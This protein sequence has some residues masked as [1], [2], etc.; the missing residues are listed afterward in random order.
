MTTT[1]AFDLQGHRGARGLLPENTLPAFERAMQIGVNTLELDVGVTKDGV[2]VISHDRALNPEITRDATGAYLTAPVLVNKLTLAEIK[3]YDV[4]R[5]NPDS[6]YA[7]RFAQQQPID[8]T[9]MPALSTLFKRVK[10]IEAHQQQALRAAGPPQGSMAPSGGGSTGRAAPSVGAGVQ[11]NIETKISPEKSHE[12]V[13]PSV[14][15]RKLMDVIRKHGMASRVT[16]QS[17]DWRTLQLIAEMQ[18]GQAKQVKLSCLT[19]QQPWTNNITPASGKG[20]FWTGSVRAADHPDVPSMVKAA[21]C[22][23]WSPYFADITPALVSKA[24]TLGLKV[25]PWTTNTEAD[26]ATVIDAGA[27]GLITDYPDRA[28]A[29]LLQRGIKVADPVTISP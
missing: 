2:V 21:G 7:K 1:F 25:I 22:D 9:R 3:T 28:R 12:T 29:L 24:K 15:A 20:P 8:G 10:E 17:F 18:K 27:D 11:F 5:I 13:S 14:F 19:A 4:G 6:A 23:T 16:V 26:M